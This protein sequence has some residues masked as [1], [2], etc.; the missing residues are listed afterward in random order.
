MRPFFSDKK[1]DNNV[2]ARFVYRQSPKLINPMFV[3]QRHEKMHDGGRRGYDHPC[4][5]AA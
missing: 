5:P 2:K 1:M 3:Q 4:S